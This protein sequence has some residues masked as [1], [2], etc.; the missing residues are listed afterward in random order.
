MAADENGN[1]TTGESG[2]GNVVGRLI[3]FTRYPVP[4]RTKTRLIGAIGAVRAAWLQ[5]EMTAA[6]L[7]TARQFRRGTALE[8]EVRCA[9]ASRGRMRRWLGRDVAYTAQGAGDVGERMKR[10]FEEAFG[11]G[12]GKVVLVGTDCPELSAG[13]LR[14]AFAALDVSD[15]ALSPSADG[16]YWLIGLRRRADVFADIAW[17]TESVLSQTLQRAR[18]AG[19]SV[20][21]LSML[22]DVDRGENLKRLPSTLRTIVEQPYVSVIVP[23]LN[24]IAHIEAT[25]ASA[26]HEAAEVIVVD[27]G[28]ADGTVEAARRA[29]AR[30]IVSPP[31]RGRQMNAGAELARGK[32]LLFLHG[33]TSLPAGYIEHVF[34]AFGDSGVVGGAFEFGTDGDTPAGRATETLINLRTKHMGLPYGDQAIFLRT[35]VFEA[36]GGYEDLPL[37]EDVRLVRRIKQHGRLA[38]VPAAVVTSGRRW[39]TLGVIKPTIINALVMIGHAVGV[40]TAR[41]ARLYGVRRAEEQGACGATVLRA[42]EGRVK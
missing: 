11:A 33:D 27:G 42:A 6:V 13:H 15:L 22:T 37:M 14:E 26:L 36:V 25:V 38:I 31:G 3:V 23:A 32:V 8:I 9:G 41:L 19:L 35:D 5:R 30:V 18:A 1:D 4:G 7:D 10:A 39:K 29:G 34:E 24:E 17:S 28:S 20:R 12:G 21:T 40:P 16:G 2:R